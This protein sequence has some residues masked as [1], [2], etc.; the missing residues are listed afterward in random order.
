MMTLL[1]GLAMLASAEGKEGKGGEHPLKAACWDDV[2][3]LCPGT[4]NPGICIE[5]KWDAVSEGCRAA[6][7]EMKKKWQGG[8]KGDSKDYEGVKAACADD[9][10]SEA[11][12]EAKLAMK[13]KMRAKQGKKPK[14][15][16]QP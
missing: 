7:L 2:Q 16:E 15:T 12:L 11:C 1:L 9:H 5:E 8:H 13:R 10:E 3:K 14:P 4:N 6:K